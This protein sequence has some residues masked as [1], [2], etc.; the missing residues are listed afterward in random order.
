MIQSFTEL[1]KNQSQPSMLP[2]RFNEPS[3]KKGTGFSEILSRELAPP[4]GHMQKSPEL[5]MTPREEPQRASVQLDRPEEIE[6]KHDEPRRESRSITEKTDSR[7]K[8]KESTTAAHKKNTDDEEQNKKTEK[9]D[10]GSIATGLKSL[11]SELNARAAQALEKKQAGDTKTDLTEDIE[12]TIAALMGEE[13]ISPEAL[14]SLIKKAEELLEGIDE[15]KTRNGGREL[16]ARLKNLLK[17]NVGK[18]EISLPK[19]KET[20]K[21]FSALLEDTVKPGLKKTARK[22][23]ASS[24]HGDTALVQDKPEDTSALFQNKTFNSEQGNDRGREGF[25]SQDFQTNIKNASMKG[26]ASNTQGK[27]SRNFQ[28]QFNE[29]VQRAQ[30]VV[31]D[32]RNGVFNMKLYPRQLGSVTV[33]LGL[34]QGILNGRFLVESGDAKNLLMEN[35]ET[36]RQHL[37]E[38]GVEVGAFEVN[39][40][41]QHHAHSDRDDQPHA[42]FRQGADMTEEYL[43][44]DISAAPVHNG[45][46]NVII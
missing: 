21:E 39:V 6:R 36:V 14:R 38:A 30:V 26:A 41:D 40:R 8:P 44:Y 45:A 20:L 29:I 13:K 17:D 43:Q 35:L 5:I 19:L 34:E 24:S 32:S 16:L 4:E 42:A 12:G 10:E 2:V 31:K 9:N 23:S 28:Q 46:I 11:S 18:E 3:S 25:N 7:E 37:K 22:T 33:N 1:Q 27:A 15:K